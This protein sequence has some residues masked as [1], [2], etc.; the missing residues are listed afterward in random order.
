MYKQAV[1]AGLEP[2]QEAWAQLQMVQLARVVKREDFARS[3]LRA[4][5]VNPDSLVRRMAAILETEVPEA[6]ADKR[7]QKP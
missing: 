3:G 5:S 6:S 7:G 1:V 4:L 2:E